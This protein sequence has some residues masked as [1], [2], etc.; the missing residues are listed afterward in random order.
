MLGRRRLFFRQVLMAVK[1]PMTSSLPTFMARRTAPSHGLVFSMAASIRPFP[2]SSRPLHCGPLSPFP[3][4]KFQGKGSDHQATAKLV[5]HLPPMTDTTAPRSSGGS[6]NSTRSPRFS[7]WTT[8]VSPRN[9]RY[10][11]ELPTPA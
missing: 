6:V 8:Y 3:P 1:K 7:P 9:E 10:D 2:P 4:P 11:S 5:F